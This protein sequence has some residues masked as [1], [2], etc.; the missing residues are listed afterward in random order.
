MSDGEQQAFPKIIGGGG[1][2][3]PGMTYR[4]WL[5]GQALAGYCANSG[6]VLMDFN[7]DYEGPDKYEVMKQTAEE[8]SALVDAVL[9]AENNT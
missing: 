5:T 7:P 8:I 2:S 4:Q 6:H 9:E 3:M 1:G